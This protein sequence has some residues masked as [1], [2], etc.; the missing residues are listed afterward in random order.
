[1]IV[2]EED[3]PAYTSIPMHMYEHVH[4]H[5]HIHTVVK[6]VL[7]ICKGL[8]SISQH[9]LNPR[10]GKNIEIGVLACDCF[11]TPP[12]AHRTKKRTF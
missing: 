3:L 6:T 12:I 10:L 1:M 9:M 2:T 7:S 8:G 4:T 11:C 5:K